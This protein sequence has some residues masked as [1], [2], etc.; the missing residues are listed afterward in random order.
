MATSLFQLREWF[1]AG[2]KEGATHM[3]VVCDTYDWDDFPVYVKPGQDA[4]AVYSATHGHNMQK[5]M[6][7]YDLKADKE[8]QFR[9][10]ALVFRLCLA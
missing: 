3:L 6:E 9:G 10:S 4:R 2:V 7:V 1:D 5:V 8:S